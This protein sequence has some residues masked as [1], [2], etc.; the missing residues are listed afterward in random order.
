VTAQVTLRM[1]FR[2]AAWAG[3]RGDVPG[4]GELFAPTLDEH[5]PR[6]WA[7]RLPWR[8]SSQVYVGILG[9][10]LA[11]GVI[12]VLNARRLGM[13]RGARRLVAAIAAAGTILAIVAA[14]L[15]PGDAPRL[16]IQLGGALTYAALHRVQRAPD[17]IHTTFSPHD[18]P[19]QDYASLWVPGIAAVAAGLVVQLGLVA[20]V[21]ALA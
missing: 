8:L 19:A 15:V 9:G 14:A 16:L 7:T 21:E 20:L 3:T 12:A 13:A 18:D 4:E 1:G 5:R 2:S 6:D 10:P 11:V 17:R